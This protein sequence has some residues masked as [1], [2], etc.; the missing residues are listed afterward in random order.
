MQKA[1]LYISGIVFA[2]VAVALGLRLATDFKIVADGVVVP[3]WISFPG[4]L[5]A[6]LL[7]LWMTLEAR[8]P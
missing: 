6:A 2:A 7:A 8:R 4:A 5:I 1:A 3:L